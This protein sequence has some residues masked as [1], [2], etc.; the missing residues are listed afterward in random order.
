MLALLRFHLRGAGALAQ[1]NVLATVAA[2]ILSLVLVPDAPVV[3]GRIALGMVAKDGDRLTALIPF[4]LGLALA[5]Q[6]MPTLRLGLGGWLRSL[7]LDHRQHRRAVVTAL[8]LPQ[9][10]ILAAGLAAILVTA[11]VF[12]RPLAPAAILGI[13][14]GVLAAGAAAVPVARGWLARPAALAAG[15]LGTLGAWPAVAGGVALLVVSDLVA[16]AI[17]LAPRPL[18]RRRL[19]AGQLGVTLAYRAVGARVIGPLVVAILGVLAGWAYRVNNGFSV[20]EA[21]FGVRV[22]LVS[23]LGGSMA[24]LADA[25]MVRR[26]V[27]PWL[28]SL[29]TTAGGRVVEDAV[30]I[31]LPALVAVA[32]AIRVDWGAAVVAAATAPFLALVT[33][34]TLRRAGGKL[35]GTTGSVAWITVP[36]AVL[37]ARWPLIAIGAV[38]AAPLMYWAA[39]R[40][41]KRLI[42]TGWQPL[43]HAAAG[44]SMAGSNR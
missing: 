30:I 6:A 13:P 22:A 2:A 21:G 26:P 43:H 35:L 33:V 36:T 34:A 19:A 40:A 23:T 42:V 28:R 29:P 5:T 44:D 12:D 15:L 32:L 27:W 17:T 4:A 7:P 31:S 41:D 1:R 37:V 18:E 24:L 16:G 20:A 3:L 25:L 39:V 8:A 38:A 14:L 11:V 9:A 10:P